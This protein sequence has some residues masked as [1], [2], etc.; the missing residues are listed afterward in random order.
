MTWEEV[1]VPGKEATGQDLWMGECCGQ[2][3]WS[4]CRYLGRV[5]RLAKKWW[6]E[7]AISC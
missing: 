4:K 6:E 7:F 2:I 5:G 3:L 1:G